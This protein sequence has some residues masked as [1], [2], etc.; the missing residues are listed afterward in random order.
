MVILGD[1][2]KFIRSGPDENT[3][4]D[5]VNWDD[6]S[7]TLISLVKSKVFPLDIYEA[8]RLVAS[9]RPWL[10]DWPKTHK[11]NVSLRS[12]LS[13]VS[14]VQQVAKAIRHIVE[15]CTGVLYAQ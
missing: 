3:R 2:N 7:K 9:I 15:V 13:I 8:V 5:W 12:I 11:D 4:Q 10:Y 14:L 1:R 6:L